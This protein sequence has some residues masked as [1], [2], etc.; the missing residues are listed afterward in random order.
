M[1]ILTAAFLPVLFVFSYFRAFVINYVTPHAR[2]VFKRIAAS[3]QIE[4]TTENRPRSLGTYH[5]STKAQ[6]KCGMA[7][8]AAAF[9]PVLFVFSSFRAFVMKV[10]ARD[11]RRGAVGSTPT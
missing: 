3:S 4:R 6:K 1:A 9:L 10:E 2:S 7:I 11:A 5:E 8:Q